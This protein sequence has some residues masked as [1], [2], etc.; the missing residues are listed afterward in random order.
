MLGPPSLAR[1]ALVPA[2][3]ALSQINSIQLSAALQH[4]LITTASQLSEQANVIAGVSRL[5]VVR[6][7]HSSLTCHRCVSI[8]QANFKPHQYFINT[9]ERVQLIDVSTVFRQL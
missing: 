1:S 5:S 8:W 7:I 9:G 6:R 4:S 2:A 3:S